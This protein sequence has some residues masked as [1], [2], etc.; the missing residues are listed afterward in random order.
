MVQKI[1]VVDDDPDF[2][3]ITRTILAK[4]GYEVITAANGDE[5]LAQ[6]R[7]E[8]PDLVLL[9]IMMTTLLDGVNVSQEMH[10]D[11]ELRQIPLVMVSSIASTEHAEMFPTDEYLHVDG[12]LSKP[13][14]PQD[15]LKI[16]A[17]FG[18]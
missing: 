5:A 16:V 12:W 14:Q 1:M 10:N 9:D 4:E 8:K 2:V 17:R 6:V 7:T 11:P 18:G 3:E 13:V 15:L